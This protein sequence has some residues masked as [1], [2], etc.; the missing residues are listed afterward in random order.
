MPRASISHFK[1]NFKQLG[2]N[3]PRWQIKNSFASLH[4]KVISHPL[5]QKL[6]L[7]PWKKK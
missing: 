2:F 4:A 3:A 1:P 6:N 5:Y 7:P